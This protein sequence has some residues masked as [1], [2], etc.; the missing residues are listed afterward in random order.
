MKLDVLLLLRHPVSLRYLHNAYSEYL[1]HHA[2]YIRQMLVL[3]YGMYD[4]C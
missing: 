1:H 3:P 4:T 2:G